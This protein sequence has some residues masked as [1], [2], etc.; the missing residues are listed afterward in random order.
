M[1]RMLLILAAVVATGG[2]R[3][4]T[5]RRRDSREPVLQPPDPG[6]VSQARAS[7]VGVPPGTQDGTQG[8]TE[9]GSPAGARDVSGAGAALTTSPAPAMI[10]CC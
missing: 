3:S 10:T 6:S 7:V 8:A 5:R 1:K 4:R 2:H 9:S